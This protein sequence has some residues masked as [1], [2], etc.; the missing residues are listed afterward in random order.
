MLLALII[1]VIYTVILKII[2][3][4]IIEQ[5]Q[6]GGD[7][8]EILYLRKKL[9][10]LR[11]RSLVIILILCFALYLI[12][13]IGYKIDWYDL[14]AIGSFFMSI[15]SCYVIVRK[16]KNHNPLSVMSD[17]SKD[18]VLTSK[19]DYILFLRG[20]EQDD[21]TPKAQINEWERSFRNFSEFH[22][23][24]TL[25]QSINVYAVGM[26]KEVEAP[27]GADRVYLSDKDWKQDVLDLMVNARLIVVLVDDRESCIWEIERSIDMLNKTLF[28]V[29]DAEKYS[30]ILMSMGDKIAFPQMSTDI[31]T[32]FMIYFEGHTEPQ[33]YKFRNTKKSYRKL[34]DNILKNHLNNEYKTPFI[35]TTCGKRV[36]YVSTFII[37]TIISSLLAR[38]LGDGYSNAYIFFGSLAILLS[39]SLYI[40]K[41]MI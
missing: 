8:D 2:E 13:V 19:K 25:K 26:T 9:I 36:V 37:S 40:F 31:K 38:T 23:T 41:R 28:I 17:L 10:K 14:E 35:R 39:L 3:D 30:N 34:S 21:Y 22:F 1:V 20:F 18:D 6:V 11:K 15:F 7:F 4:P 24:S 33:L 5:I 32:P 29:D 12:Q 27:T 16:K